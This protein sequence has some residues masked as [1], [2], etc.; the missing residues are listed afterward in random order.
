MLLTTARHIHNSLIIVL[1]NAVQCLAHKKV[2]ACSTRERELIASR[3]LFLAA[4]FAL[5]AFVL[6]AELYNGDGEE[7]TQDSKAHTDPHCRWVYPA[8]CEHNYMIK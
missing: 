4:F 6:P 7:E 2:Y 3:T 5:L 1:A 8:P